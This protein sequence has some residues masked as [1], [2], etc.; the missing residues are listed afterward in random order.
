[1][2]PRITSLTA[3]DFRSLRGTV[4]VPMDS[5]VVLIHGR[6]GAGKT[7]LLTAMELGLTGNL[8]SLS[9]LDSQFQE[10]LVHKEAVSKRGSVSI[11]VHGLG[12]EFLAGHFDI[13]GHK[14]TGKAALDPV[15]TKHFSERCYLA[16][17]TLTRLLELYEV[18]SANG[19]A[20]TRFVK[21]LL[22]L[23]ALD[24]LINGLYDAGDVRRLRGHAVSFWDMREQIP[25]LDDELNRLTKELTAA[26]GQ[27][28]QLKQSAQERLTPYWPE[29]A[30]LSALAMLDLLKEQSQEPELQRF[31][32]LRREL[33]DTVAQSQRMVSVMGADQ[34]VAIETA[35]GTADAALRTW[36]DT[37]GQRMTELFDKLGGYFSDLPSPIQNRPE[38]ARAYAHRAVSNEVARCQQIQFKDQNAQQQV[39]T[40]QIDRQGLTTRL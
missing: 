31:T 19:T 11:G 25:S 39:S 16:Q 17:S 28:A 1:M 22:G 15:L 24:A 5:P 3:T 29:V 21:E 32:Q 35:A 36:L 9:R 2:T 12:V 20:L 30:S 38:Y 14:F 37:S 13:H 4:T 23:D 33:N 26:Q 40:L 6:N 34:R 18:K 27:A 10:H 7:S 8:A